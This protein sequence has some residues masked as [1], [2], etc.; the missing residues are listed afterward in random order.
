MQTRQKQI[1]QLES[2]GAAEG[3][4]Q[5]FLQLKAQMKFQTCSLSVWKQNWSDLEQT[6]RETQNEIGE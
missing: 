1:E 5:S 6:E 2:F 3:C 4:E